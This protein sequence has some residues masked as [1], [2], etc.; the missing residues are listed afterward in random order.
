MLVDTKCVVPV[1]GVPFSIVT[2]GIVVYEAS[3][4]AESETSIQMHVTGFSDGA[5][6]SLDCCAHPEGLS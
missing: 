3:Q 4:C 2:I 1:R 6:P 5:H